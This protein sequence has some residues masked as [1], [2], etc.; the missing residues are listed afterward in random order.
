MPEA[1]YRLQAAIDM[2]D[3]AKA[4]Q[5]ADSCKALKPMRFQYSIGI[6]D[7]FLLNENYADAIEC[8][9]KSESVRSGSAS[10]RLAKTYCIIGD[11]ANCFEWLRKNLES[12]QREKES[13][14]LLESAFEKYH[15]TISWKNLW[16]KDWYTPLDKAIADAE[17]FNSN[18]NYEETLDL[19][20]VRI[21]GI[22]SR[23]VLYEL[24]GDAYFNMDNLTA[25]ADDY[26][27]AYQKSKKDPAYL[28]K[29][30]QTLMARK[31]YQLAIKKM[32]DAIEQSG[33]NPRFRLMRA[34]IYNAMGQSANGLE[35]VKYYL[36]FYPNDT[37]AIELLSQLAYDVGQYVDALFALAKLS[38]TNPNSP[39]YRYL[40][41]LVYIKTEQMRLAI[42]ELD[43]AII[44]E[45]NIADS[46]FYKGVALYNLGELKEACKC[47]STSHQYGKF[48]A[49]EWMFRLCKN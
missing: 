10:Y 16:S 36:D 9:S 8:F 23:Y 5:W 35:D 18:Q 13:T 43:F 48:E 28:V 49:Q 47:F 15:N 44:N 37:R 1:Y 14:I 7:A 17:Y 30:A 6:G 34:N 24:R 27:I 33:E 29:I 11:T 41:G 45:Y 26:S 4:L 2:Q 22:K 25:A 39:K 38:K 32:D 40:R 19:L 12:V 3:R 21:K 20:N 42:A 31:Q 46:Y